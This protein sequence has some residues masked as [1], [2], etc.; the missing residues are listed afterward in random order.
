MGNGCV[1]GLIWGRRNATG[2]WVDKIPPSLLLTQESCSVCVRYLLLISELRMSPIIHSANHFS[3]TRFPEVYLY[4]RRTE[5]EI[6]SIF[7]STPITQQNFKRSSQRIFG[8]NI[9]HRTLNYFV[10]CRRRLL[11]YNLKH[12]VTPSLM[13]KTMYCS[14]KLFKIFTH[15]F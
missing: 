12:P 1:Y 13:S 10:R 4:I 15:T 2:F 6:I 11:E 9:I 3:Q 8:V 14:H 7:C 5:N